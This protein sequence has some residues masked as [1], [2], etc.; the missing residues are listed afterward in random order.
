MLE[1]RSLDMVRNHAQHV[2]GLR[3]CCINAAHEPVTQ[4]RI[5][6]ER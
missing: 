5:V 6:T 4:P 3:A 1:E 2:E